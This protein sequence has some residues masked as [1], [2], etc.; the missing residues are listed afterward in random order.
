MTTGT[1]GTYTLCLFN[2]CKYPPQRLA[3]YNLFPPSRC[4]NWNT[5]LPRMNL[6]G[7]GLYMCYGRRT[8]YGGYGD[9]ARGSRQVLLQENIP[10][11][12]IKTW[13]RLED[14]TDKGEISLSPTY[15]QNHGMESQGNRGCVFEIPFLYMFIYLCVI[16]GFL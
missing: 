3:D 9:W 5:S 4:F 12:P 7:D 1:T 6:T 8:G 2:S 10:E 16:C 11:V 13:I 14:G 15:S